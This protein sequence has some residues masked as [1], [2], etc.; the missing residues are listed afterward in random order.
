MD[1]ICGLLKYSIELWYRPN[2]YFE[3]KIFMVGQ[4]SLEISEN[5]PLEKFRLYGI[6]ML[7]KVQ[8]HAYM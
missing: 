2:S 7:T 8:F 6:I 1:K 5:F 4:K 3:D